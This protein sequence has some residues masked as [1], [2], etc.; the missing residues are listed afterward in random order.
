MPSFETS[1]HG[2]S[3]I[4]LFIE[5]VC[6]S[7]DVQVNTISSSSAWRMRWNGYVEREK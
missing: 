4:V 7:L 1:V 5:F 2:F 6:D 3:A